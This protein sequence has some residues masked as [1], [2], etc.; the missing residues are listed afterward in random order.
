MR[1]LTLCV[2]ITWPAF[3]WRR[4]LVFVVHPRAYFV[5]I[6]MLFAFNKLA[7]ETVAAG[8]SDLILRAFISLRR[9]VDRSLRLVSYPRAEGIRNVF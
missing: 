8:V 6:F 7:V 5:A 1:Y 4:W 3:M 9:H 2:L